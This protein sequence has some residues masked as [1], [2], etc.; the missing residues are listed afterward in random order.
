MW[1]R[2]SSWTAAFAVALGLLVTN[3]VGPALAA[4]SGS[5]DHVESNEGTVN[6]LF[7]VADLDEN[8]SPDLESVVV[9]LGKAPVEATAVPASGAAEQIERVAVLAIDV[10]QSMEGAAFEEAKQAAAAFME[11]APDDVSIGL[12][13]FADTVDTVQE[14]TTD[15]ESLAGALDELQLSRETHL[16]DG[17][18]S[19]LTAA[20]AEGQRQVL[21][22]SDGADTTQSDLALVNR[23]IRRSGIRVDVVSLGQSATSERILSRMAAIG[24]GTLLNASDPTALTALFADE[25]QALASQI[26]VSFPVPDEL[27][28]SDADLTVSLAADGTTYS[29][30]AFVSLGDA[31]PSEK[32]SSDATT[33]LP[34]EAPR[35]VISDRLLMGGV[36]AVGL[37]ILMLVGTAL[38]VFRS[39]ERVTVEGR[40]AGYGRGAAPPTTQD[41]A[42]GNVKESAVALAQKTIN[43]S[44]EAKL[45]KKLDAAGISLKAAEWVLTHTGIAVGAAFVGFL[46]GSGSI[47]YAL[48]GLLT[49]TVLPWAYLHFKRTRRLAAFNSQ[50]GETLQLISGALSAG[51]SLPQALDTI[52]REGTEPIAG[53]FRR[54]LVEARLGVEIEDALD[55]VADRMNSKDFQWVVMAIRIQREVGGNLSEL[56]LNVSTTLREREFLRRQ[57][58]SLSAEGRLSALI[59]CALPPLFMVYLM[60]TQDGYLTP[61]FSSLIGWMMV[62]VSVV[63]MAVGVF[64]M[65]RVVKVEV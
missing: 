11:Q 49:G 19:A 29:D 48:L 47:I 25:A 61:M 12:V 7:S 31:A 40:L 27:A 37:G 60:L 3:S 59:L 56:L 28:N 36:G 21:I 13:T 14:P 45:N 55:G 52:M 8:A 50:L 26:L 42:P 9:S 38:G 65:S 24:E 6:V 57:V 1:R 22:L 62:V 35:F 16:Y 17:V 64:W 18:T 33:P 23:A 30:N 41:V 4:G 54:V 32:V 5:I 51:L 53:E 43:R 44:R 39:K 20:G 10:S 58:R 34:V 63:L 46:I 15:R 2:P